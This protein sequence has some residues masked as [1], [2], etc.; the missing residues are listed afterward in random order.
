MKAYKKGCEDFKAVVDNNF[1]KVEEF[2]QD[3]KK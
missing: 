2:F 3:D 1:K